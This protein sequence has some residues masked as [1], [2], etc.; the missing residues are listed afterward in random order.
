MARNFYDTWIDA[1]SAEIER[2]M[3]AR[4]LAGIFSGSVYVMPSAGA[5]AGRLVLA[6]ETPAGACDVVRFPAQGTSVMAVP[7]T[8]L[9]SLLWNACRSFP[10][11]PTA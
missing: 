10:I 8:H 1:N 7:R 11:L 9:R 6:D 2:G 3:R 5:T 4:G